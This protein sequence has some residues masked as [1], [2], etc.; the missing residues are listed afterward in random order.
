MIMT[1][2]WH[3]TQWHL[4]Y[5]RAD[6]RKTDFM[7]WYAKQ[8]KLIGFGI[9]KTL[10]E[11]HPRNAALLGMWTLLE[12]LASQSA[13]NER[14]WLIRGGAAM[15]YEDMSSLLPTIPAAAFEEA[16]LWFAQPKINWVEHIECPHLNGTQPALIPAHQEPSGKNSRHVPAHQE[17]SGKNSATDRQT[18]SKQTDKGKKIEKNGGFA[19]KEE[20]RKALTNQFAA[21]STR[22]RELEAIL[23]EDRTEEQE[24]ELKKMAALVQKIQKKQ[25]RG[26]FTPVVEDEK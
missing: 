5:E 26:D 15:D 11:P 12:T 18:D 23:E 20:A 9:G 4:K 13:M 14:G 10:R 6:T 17:P 16:L 3:I 19:S 2:A 25:R 8:T 24:E 21:V 1:K 22:K 7:G